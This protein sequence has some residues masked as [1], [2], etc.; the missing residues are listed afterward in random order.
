[1]KLTPLCQEAANVRASHLPAPALG[2]LPAAGAN[3]QLSLRLHPAGHVPSPLS[4]SVC[5]GGSWAGGPGSVRGT[6]CRKCVHMALSPAQRTSCKVMKVNGPQR[7]TCGGGKG[8]QVSP[9]E[10]IQSLCAQGWVSS[11]LSFPRPGTAPCFGNARWSQPHGAGVPQSAEAQAGAA[12][13]KRDRV[14]KA[15][16]AAFTYPQ[17]CS[18]IFLESF[19]ESKRFCFQQVQDLSHVPSYHFKGNLLPSPAFCAEGSKAAGTQ[20]HGKL[21]Q[22]VASKPRQPMAMQLALTKAALAKSSS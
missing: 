3:A 17:P 1:M 14:G 4:D 18:C 19:A 21:S 11:K 5:K 22:T 10:T 13:V 16:G 2:R 7:T 8:A 9:P 15:M 12:M 20:H 6:L